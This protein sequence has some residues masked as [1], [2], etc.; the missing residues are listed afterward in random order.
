[1]LRLVANM[2]LCVGKSCLNRAAGQEKQLHERLGLARH[3]DALLHEAKSH[4]ETHFC[5]RPPA[6]AEAHFR[7]VLWRSYIDWRPQS[8]EGTVDYGIGLKLLKKMGYKEVGSLCIVSG[9]FIDE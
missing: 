7:L 5:I 4:A 3:A 1:M 6:H 2:S 8:M 9:A